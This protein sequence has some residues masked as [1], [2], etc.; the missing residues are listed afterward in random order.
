M[1]L[2]EL[3][4]GLCEML[5]RG[6]S[7]VRLREELESAIETTL[8]KLPSANDCVVVERWNSRTYCVRSQVEPE[9]LP[10]MIEL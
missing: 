10:Y 1:Q 6:V 7:P 5:K 9:D 2:D 3:Y 4:A 8:G